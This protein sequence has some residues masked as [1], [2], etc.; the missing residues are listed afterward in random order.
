MYGIFTYMNG[1]FLWFSCRE[2]YHSHGC[3][4]L[5]L[6][7]RRLLAI[8]RLCPFGMV[9]TRD[10]NSKVTC[11]WPPSFGA[12]K[13]TL[14]ESPGIWVVIQNLVAKNSKLKPCGWNSKLKPCGWV[15]LNNPQ[16]VY[17]VLDGFRWWFWM[18]FN[19]FCNDRFYAAFFRFWVL[20]ESGEPLGWVST[21]HPACLRLWMVRKSG[22]H[23]LRLVVDPII[24]RFL[25]PSQVVV[26][27]FSH[28]Q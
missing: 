23:Q 13:V 5:L 22:E 14:L 8:L 18:D 20:E 26:W 25:A 24:Y 9:K 16:L 15:F 11:W 21:S 2:I 10:P 28:Q 4:G 17:G 1:W 7:K 19:A 3:Y 12:K 27:D 6:E